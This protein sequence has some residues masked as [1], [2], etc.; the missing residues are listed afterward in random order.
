MLKKSIFITLLL[1]SLTIFITGCGDNSFTDSLPAKQIDLSRYLGTWYEI[2]RIPNWFEKDLQ[3]VT[4][5]YTL[6]DNGRIEVKNQGTIKSS[7]EQKTAIGEAWVDGDYKIGRLQVSFFFLVSAPYVVFEL[8][9]DY[10][11]ALVGSGKD[12]LWILSRLPLLDGETYKYLLSK[13]SSAGYDVS[14]LEKIEH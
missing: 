10:S 8:A 5:T 11:Y 13:A 12:Y 14:R 7:K 3:K 9:P 6:K 2:A 4:A 1:I